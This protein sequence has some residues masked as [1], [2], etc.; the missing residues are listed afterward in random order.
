MINPERI[1][2]GPWSAFSR[3]L[4]PILSRTMAPCRGASRAIAR[5]GLLVALLAVLAPVYLIL[6]QSWLH[7]GG[8]VI[9]VN[10]FTDPASTS[11]NGFCTLR[12]AINNANAASDTPGGDCVAGTGTDTINFSLSGTITITRTLPE[13]SNTSPGSCNMGRAPSSSSPSL[14]AVLTAAKGRNVRCTVL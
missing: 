10:N 13:V 3:R 7:A 11:G 14:V 2:N 9:T 1:S 6:S 4:E 12:E 8:N 5:P